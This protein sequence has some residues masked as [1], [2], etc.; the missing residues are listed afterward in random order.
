[1]FNLKFFFFIFKHKKWLWGTRIYIKYLHHV[2]YHDQGGHYYV[3][4]VTRSDSKATSVTRYQRRSY[5]RERI[6]RRGLALT[7]LEGWWLPPHLMYLTKLPDCIY[8][9]KIS[10]QFCLD[11]PNSPETWE[12][13]WWDKYLSSGLDDQ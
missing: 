7:W 11:C 2:S 1:M 9:E 8:V 10:E 4:E 6:S 3:E 5:C 12:G 13:V